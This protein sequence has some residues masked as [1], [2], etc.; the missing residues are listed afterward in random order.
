M[1]GDKASYIYL[2]LTIL[3]WSATPAVAKL[4][5]SELNNI[6]LLFYCNI[7]GI[8]SLSALVITQNKLPV[9]SGYSKLDYL[10]M[11]GMGFLGLY[12]YYIFL[13]GS[14]AIAPPGQANMIN[15][16]WPIFVVLFSILVLRE[17]ST[18]KT[19]LAIAMGFA[20]ALIV[21]TGGNFSSLQ[22]QYTGGYLLALGGAVC[23]GLFSVLGK[24]LN[25][26]TFPLAS[27]L[28]LALIVGGVLVQLK[29]GD[30]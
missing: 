29:S 30:K 23:Y 3:L 11:F 14:F 2:G 26:E 18:W 4:A 20:G 24:K 8:L 21:F 7:V 17:K 12:L 16:L 22:N 15:Y 9:F 1:A 28:G 13:Y 27:L 25:G 6:Q 19:F 10:K 5:L